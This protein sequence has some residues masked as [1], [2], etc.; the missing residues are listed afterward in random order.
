MLLIVID[1]IDPVN[2]F[3][4]THGPNRIHGIVGSNPAQMVLHALYSSG[5]PRGMPML[6]RPMCGSKLP[7]GLSLS[8]LCNS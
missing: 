6:S 4:D 8:C 1:V 5:T 2:I 7:N 3:C